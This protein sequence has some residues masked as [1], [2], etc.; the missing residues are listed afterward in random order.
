ML[1]M[2][3]RMLKIVPE[4]KGISESQR[5]SRMLS[6]HYRCVAKKLLLNGLEMSCSSSWSLEGGDGLPIFT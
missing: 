6:F 3:K 2:V 5:F 4:R 1:I